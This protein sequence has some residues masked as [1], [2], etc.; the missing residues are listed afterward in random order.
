MPMWARISNISRGVRSESKR[1]KMRISPESGVRRPLASFM[2]TL[3]PQPAGPRRMRVSPWRTV[4]EMS[5][6][7]VSRSKPMETCENSTMGEPGSRSR[8]ARAGAGVAIA[9]SPEDANHELRYEEVEEDDEH[10]ADD[11]G[12]GGGA[13][14]ALCA[15]G[16]A[17][18]VEAADGGDDEAGEERLG[19]AFDDVSEDERLEGGVE[20]CAALETEEADC[21][22]R[23]AG[24]AAGVGHDGEEEEHEDSGNQAR[25]DE[26]AHG[27]GAE[28]AHG[29]DLLGDLHGA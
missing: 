8:G 13:P 16:G 23:A 17:Q 3:L 29:V 14:N 4:K 19:D 2:M 28:R 18:A 1:P 21:D 5:L 27:V 11:D 9:L 6:R 7:T 10:G 12:L 20:E 26:L 25:R 15:A 24:D 22:E